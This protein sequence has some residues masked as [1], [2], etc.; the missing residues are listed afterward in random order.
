MFDG[1][2]DKLDTNLLTSPSGTAM[3]NSLIPGVK[4]RGAPGTITRPSL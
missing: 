4:N 3:K 1:K 2:I